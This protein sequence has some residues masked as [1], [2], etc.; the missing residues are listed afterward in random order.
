MHAV[1]RL[2]SR[3]CPLENSQRLPGRGLAHQHRN[4]SP[5]ERRVALDVLAKLVVRRRADAGKLSARQ[6]RLEL[7][8]CV[9]RAFSCAARAD[10]HVQLVD[11]NNHAS[12]GPLHIFL[13]AEESLAERAAQR[14]ARDHPADIQLDDDAI[15][16]LRISHASGLCRRL[17]QLCKAQCEALDD[18]GLAHARLADQHGIVRATLAENVENL[19]D[20]RLSADRGVERSRGRELR[21]IATVRREPGILLRIEREAATRI[22]RDADGPRWPARFVQTNP[23][24]AHGTLAEV[25]QIGRD[26]RERPSI[27]S[28]R[29]GRVGEAVRAR[30]RCL[31]DGGARSVRKGRLRNRADP[32]RAA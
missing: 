24:R 27:E 14:G 16:R 3:R 21:E 2:I 29:R 17:R 23:R 9:L 8:G 28:L 22:R 20:L 18:R 25:A 30:D 15:K 12:V 13:D 4:E 1:V 11:E 19:L 31:G 6:R 26:K 7:V 5:L 10:E 32:A